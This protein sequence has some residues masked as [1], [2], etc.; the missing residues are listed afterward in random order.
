MHN[1]Q[2]KLLRHL[3]IE[4]GVPFWRARRAITEFQDHY[5]DLHEEALNAGLEPAEAAADAAIR[6][7]NVSCIADEYLQCEE[8]TTWWG[9]LPAL[10]LCVAE[11]MEVWQEQSANAARWCFAMLAAALLTSI[12]MLVLQLSIFGI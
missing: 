10:Q 4:G 6:F 8:L 1:S 2:W 9:R 5:F 3:L 11:G 12:L 7:G